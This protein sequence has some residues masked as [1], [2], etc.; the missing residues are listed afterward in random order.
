MPVSALANALAPE[1][2]SQAD[3]NESQ[4]QPE[5]GQTAPETPEPGAGTAE[6]LAPSGAATDEGN[7]EAPEGADQ[8]AGGATEEE[9]GEPEAG[10]T[11]G[12]KKRIGQLQGRIRE[13]E[14]ELAKAKETPAPQRGKAEGALSNI[15]DLAELETRQMK[16][17]AALDEIESQLPKL[18]INPRAV[19]QYL[20][21][22]GIKLQDGT[23]EEDYSVERMADFLT[24]ARAGFKGTLRE[25]PRRRQYLADY[26]VAHQQCVKA[27]PWVADKTDDRHA[28]MHQIVGQ[29][30][31]LKAAPNWEYWVARAIEGHLAG[32]ATNKRVAATTRQ[33]G[34][35]Q[36]GARRVGLP[37]SGGQSTPPAGG[38]KA[39]VDAARNAVFKNGDRKA[40]SAFFETI[41]LVQ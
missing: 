6:D 2:E 35:I 9:P 4:V 32:L 30:P 36:N 13:L 15:T 10:D 37:N 31:G 38:A 28:M 1:F 41:G 26:A 25:I 12:V 27:I 11:P 18:S 5:P 40:L 23:G 34:T 21:E 22:N 7:L 24:Q 16:A 17:E 20:R 3:P 8:E 33:P 29:F 39:K 14:T 19:E